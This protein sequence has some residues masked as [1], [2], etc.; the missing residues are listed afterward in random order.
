MSIYAQVVT[1][2]SWLNY[3]I[4]TLLEQLCSTFPLDLLRMGRSVVLGAGTDMLPECNRVF[5]FFLVICLVKDI[6]SIKREEFENIFRGYNL[7]FAVAGA[8]LKY[9]T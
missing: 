6:C 4:H 3:I 9:R 7:F 2:I 1:V 5:S 8:T